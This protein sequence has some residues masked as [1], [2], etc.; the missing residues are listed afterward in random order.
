[1]K[2]RDVMSI[3]LDTILTEREFNK[4]AGVSEEYYPI[5]EFME[6]EPLPPTNA[7]FD[8]PMEEIVTMWE[9]DVVLDQF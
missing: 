9:K 4:R 1:M 3:G 7:V 2:V 8:V 6:E 5:P